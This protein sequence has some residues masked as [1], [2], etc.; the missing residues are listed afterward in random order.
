[1]KFLTKEE[2]AAEMSVCTDVV[3]DLIRRGRLRAY[4][5]GRAAY[6][7][8]EADL[9]AYIDSCEVK[10]AAPEAPAVKSVGIR[11]INRRRRAQE[12]AQRAYVPGMKVVQP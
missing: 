1:M 6:R 5:F 10:P 9:F 4:K 8:A 7:I 3:D 12:E 2:A 11:D